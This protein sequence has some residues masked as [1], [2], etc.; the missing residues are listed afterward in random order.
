MGKGEK[1]NWQS[2]LLETVRYHSK[3]VLIVSGAENVRETAGILKR[4]GMEHCRV[5]TG[6][7]LS[8]PE[9]KIEECSVEECTQVWKEG[10]YTLMILN[11]TAES[12]YL[13]PKYRD[14][15]FIRGK[16]P[17]TKEE[18]RSTV[19]SKLQ[20]TKDAVVYDIGSGTGSVAV[21]TAQRSG[22]IRVLAV[23]RKTEGVEM[24][25]QN[26]EKFGLPNITVVEGEAPDCLL[27]LP[28]PTHAF[29]GGS[30]G[31]LKE[32]LNVLYRKN[33]SMRI[34]VTAVSMETVAEIVQCLGE[35]RIRE[36]EMIQ[37]QVS[38]SRHAGRYHLMQAENPVYI[39]NFNFT[40]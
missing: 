1:E 11:P 32:I 34:V 13:A 38:R 28:V 33:P 23:E 24:I 35:Y 30:N 29:I 40:S 37:V 19:I 2:E 39:C 10:L 20:L 22:K 6:F 5:I 12:K 25:R 14:E 21:E 36:E 4:Y 15:E 16:V 27:P 26:A 9:E 7:Q 17:M 18:V 3:S 31:K 8:Y